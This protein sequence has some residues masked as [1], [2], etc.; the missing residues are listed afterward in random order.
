MAGQL[1]R[2][3][4]DGPKLLKALLVIWRWVVGERAWDGDPARN[5]HFPLWK[6]ENPAEGW[7]IPFRMVANSRKNLSIFR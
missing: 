6:A 1:W 4:P 3:A 5:A 7:Q 2:R